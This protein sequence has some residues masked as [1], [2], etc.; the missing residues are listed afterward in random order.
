MDGMGKSYFKAILM[1]SYV[2]VLQEIP[3]DSQIFRNSKIGIPD[4][5]YTIIYNN[6]Y[7]L[8]YTIIIYSN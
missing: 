1:L 2:R 7:S 8:G 5:G 4:A 3:D 6:E